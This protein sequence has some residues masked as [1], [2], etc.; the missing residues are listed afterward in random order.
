MSKMKKI[1][2]ERLEKE[3]NQLNAKMFYLISALLVIALS[4]KIV[5]KLPMHVYGLEI[6][7]L[8]ASFSYVL[9]AR[10]R[11]GI[12]LVKEKDGVLTAIKEEILAKGFTI[13]FWI[14]G[15]GEF[16]LIIC[17]FQNI[18]WYAWYLA[19]ELIPS[20]II[21]VFSVKKGWL[22]WGGQKRQK[23]GKK[24]LRKRVVIGALFYGLI[25]GAPQLYQDG[26]FHAEGI[27]WILGMAVLWGVPFY[28]LFGLLVDIGERKA[29][30]QVEEVNQVEE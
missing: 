10:I 20:L 29:N 25:M 7:C 2:D 23:N 15:I 22:L 27:L 3:S 1:K 11:K 16:L 18:F 13:D 28:F 17:D 8:V 24:E 14:L 5:N 12:L 9:I 6:L 26:A 30:K 21:T 19:I 4:V